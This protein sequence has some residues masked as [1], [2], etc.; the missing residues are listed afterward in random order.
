MFNDKNNPKNFK[1]QSNQVFVSRLKRS[2]QTTTSSWIEGAQKKDANV[3]K[4]Q[5]QQGSKQNETVSSRNLSPSNFLSDSSSRA[6]GK[7]PK[8]S[9]GQ[10]FPESL[11]SH[12]YM[13]P[14]KSSLRRSITLPAIEESKMEKLA[15]KAD[16]RSG[17]HSKDHRSL[18]LIPL[19]QVKQV[20]I[21][22]THFE[23]SRPPNISE[24]PATIQARRLIHRYYKSHPEKRRKKGEKSKSL[25]EQF[26]L[27]KD[28]RY[29][30]L[31]DETGKV[32]EAGVESDLSSQD[33]ANK[34]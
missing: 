12:T 32:H 6:L 20:H 21:T 24:T 25:E 4:S 15:W 10:T 19:K 1:M 23:S 16:L 26:E 29:L 34:N 8:L 2:T 3:K 11:R 7:G 33:E 17:V 13:N 22:D 18:P 9:K 5:E 30:R 27:L 31:S 14:T 28:C